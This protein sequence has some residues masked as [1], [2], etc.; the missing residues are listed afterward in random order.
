MKAV[1][2]ILIGAVLTTLACGGG[3]TPASDEKKP[4]PSLVLERID[5]SG[6]FSLDEQKGKVV[7]IE[8]NKKRFSFKLLNQI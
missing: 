7:L 5:G 2:W 6:E 4:A 1:L 3:P 8:F